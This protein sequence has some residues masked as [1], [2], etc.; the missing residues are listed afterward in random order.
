MFV[1]HGGRVASEKSAPSVNDHSRRLTV[2]SF[3]PRSR[4]PITVT[5]RALVESKAL[6]GLIR[7]RSKHGAAVHLTIKVRSTTT[8]GDRST[9]TLKLRAG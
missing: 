4:L 5:D 3:I 9:S 6:S 2:G 7:H 8:T 1:Q